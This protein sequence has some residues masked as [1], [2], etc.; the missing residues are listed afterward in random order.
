VLLL[1][2]VKC[3]NDAT[4]MAMTRAEI[5]LCAVATKCPTVRTSSMSFVR[6]TRNERSW[7]SDM[8]RLV[9]PGVNTTKAPGSREC[10]WLTTWQERLKRVVKVVR[11]R[12]QCVP[13]RTQVPSVL[14]L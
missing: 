9:F 3:P 13:R 1:A 10:D 12:L 7:T 8:A 2:Q 11:N 5:A 6:V 14:M 4:L